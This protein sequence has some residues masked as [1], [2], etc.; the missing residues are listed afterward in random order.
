VDSHGYEG[1]L[2]PPFYDALL[3]KVIVS[4]PTRTEALAAARA[5]LDEFTVDGI[6]TNIPLLRRI[7][8]APAMHDGTVTTDWLTAQLEEVAIGG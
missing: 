4:R 7:L 2:F 6:R 3:A 5:A 1:Y 8:D